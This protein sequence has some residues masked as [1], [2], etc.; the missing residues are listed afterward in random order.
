MSTRTQRLAGTVAA[1]AL[2]CGYAVSGSA[3]EVSGSGTT[4]GSPMSSNL[5]PVTQSMLDA[6]GGDAKNWVHP[7]GN[8]DQT[9]L[10]ARSTRPTWAS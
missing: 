7:N 1:L 8:Y 3:Q 6:A 9:L 5:V 2:A 10:P 4:T